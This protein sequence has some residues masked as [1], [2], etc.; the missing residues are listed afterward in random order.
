MNPGILLVDDEDN[1]LQS[2]TRLLRRDEYEIHVANNGMKA[3][4]VLG[5]ADIALI[6]CDQRMPGM[7]GAEVLAEA[8][9]L[10]PDTI[11]ITLTGFTDLASAQASINVG[12]VNQF[13]LKPWNDDQLR[14]VVR[15]GV[16]SYEMSI[17][18]RRL[19]VLVRQQKAELEN[20]NHQLEHLVQE[21]TNELKTQN[22]QLLNLQRQLEQSLRGTV[23][24]LVGILETTCPALAIHS[25]RVAGLSRQLGARLKLSDS[26]QLDIE[27]AAHLHEIG[28][29]ASLHSDD[30]HRRPP[31][32]TRPEDSIV[33]HA[34]TGCS[35]LSH[36]SGFTSVAK[37]VRHQHECFDGTGSPDGLKQK[38]IPLG[39]RIIAVT[40]AFDEIAH[41][42][43][44]PDAAS[45]AEA[46]QRLQEKSGKQLDPELVRELLASLDD[47]KI[48]SDTETEISPRQISDGMILARDLVSTRGIMLLN[49]GTKLTPQIAERIRTWS[50]TYQLQD[51]LFVTWSPD[52]EFPVHHE[53][54]E[55]TEHISVSKVAPHDPPAEREH[56]EV[57][58]RLAE[59][60]MER[61]ETPTANAGDVA[62][63]RG[64]PVAASPP[65]AHASVRSSLPAGRILIVDDS[66]AI[67]NALRRELVQVRF[68]VVTTQSGEAALQLVA[69]NA[70]DVVIT[71][72]RM[73]MMDGEQLIA[74]LAQK[75]PELPCIVITGN[76]EKDQILRLA[77]KP[78]LAGM[79]VKPW[80]HGQLIAA[81][82][83][84]MR[85][86]RLATVA[87]GAR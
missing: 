35:I 40:N 32:S 78:N 67:C 80:N 81:I 62:A 76:A 36:I 14:A 47:P 25:K 37:A 60:T 26:E 20:W 24:V 66:E 52:F 48:V 69:N 19:D 56:L 86:T 44:T 84:A 2:L 59:P 63:I 71:D 49:A 30:S 10:R 18:N 79:L 50:D 13:L 77:K 82:S 75:F 22:E 29:L 72:L 61:S 8:Y 28:K 43:P 39:A 4:E 16:R 53:P 3:L 6:I 74:Q 17:E 57:P 23:T 64:S 87:R 31:K 21:R 9:R 58:N 34:E 51:G 46:K 65:P 41:R 27:F 1:I 5:K 7:S 73:P 15:E 12:H 11:R 33:M 42:A 54:P 55:P 83:S 68:E 38:K 70:F 45:L 85:G